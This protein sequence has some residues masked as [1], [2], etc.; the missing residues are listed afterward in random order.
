MKI[1]GTAPV[2]TTPTRRKD[3]AGGAARGAFAAELSLG[4]KPAAVTGAGPVDTLEALLSVQEVPDASDRAKRA[5][6]RGEDMLD[7]LDELRYALLAG[8]MP[9]Q[10]LDNLARLLRGRNGELADPRL[11]S[12]LD[13]IE[14][15]CRVELA[16]LESLAPA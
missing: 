3:A 5:V 13:D 11:A 1:T 9:R 15:R 2:R 16:K 12:V 7:R 14:L 4:A 10:Q 6:R 8:A